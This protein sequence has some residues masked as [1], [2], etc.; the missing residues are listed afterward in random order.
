MDD[1]NE[2]S[3]SVVDYRADLPSFLDNGKTL[4]LKKLLRELAKNQDIAVLT[5]VNLMTR[6]TVEDK[7]KLQ[8]A[9]SLLELHVK[10]ADKTS[11]DQIARLIAEVKL[12]PTGRKQL[13]NAGEDSTVPMVDFGT[14]QKIA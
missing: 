1:D 6:D 14:V 7:I 12:N 9:T 13:T 4:N 11:Q 10:V 8:A 2:S 3:G 5:L